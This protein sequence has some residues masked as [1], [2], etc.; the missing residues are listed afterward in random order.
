MMGCPGTTIRRNGHFVI[1]P[2]SARSPGP[3]VRRVPAITSA[4]SVS[5]R[6]AD[7]SRNPFSAFFCRRAQTLMNTRNASVGGRSGPPIRGRKN[8]YYLSFQVLLR[9]LRRHLGVRRGGVRDAYWTPT[10]RRPERL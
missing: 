1:S 7:F 6:P 8:D 3:S 4:C 2:C 5:R 10:V 9:G